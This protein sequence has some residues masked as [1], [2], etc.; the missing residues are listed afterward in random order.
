MIRSSREFV[1]TIGEVSTIEING[2]SRLNWE[3]GME[4][5]ELEYRENGTRFYFNWEESIN[6]TV[7]C[8]ENN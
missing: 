6:F 7:E 8:G 5:C 4:N 3:G 2:R 1:F